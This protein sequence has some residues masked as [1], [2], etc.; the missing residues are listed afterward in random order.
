M[1]HK[2]TSSKAILRS[3][4]AMDFLLSSE[5]GYPYLG[6]TNTDLQYYVETFKRD[7]A[8]GFHDEQWV[9]SAIEAGQERAAGLYDEYLEERF[10]EEWGGGKEYY[11]DSDDDGN[12]EGELKKD[13]C[14]P[15]HELV[16]AADDIQV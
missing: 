6:V 9:R 2:L 12:E 1:L 7:G 15:N 11:T 5:A 3:D 14:N 4:A 13:D 10:Q 8:N 16:D